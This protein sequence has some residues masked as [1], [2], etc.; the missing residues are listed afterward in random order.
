MRC[1]THHGRWAYLRVDRGAEI[2][3]V[4]PEGRQ[5][6]SAA[7]TLL[8][9]HSASATV[10]LSRSAPRSRVLAY[11][12]TYSILGPIVSAALRVRDAST[13]GAPVC[14]DAFTVLR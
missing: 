14:I 3:F 7:V 5:Y 2:G 11:A 8:G 4:A 6:G 1:T 10:T 13:N 9:Q 12:H